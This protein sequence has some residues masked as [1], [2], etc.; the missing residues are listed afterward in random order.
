MGVYTKRTTTTNHLRDIRTARF[1]LK[2][3]SETK[4]HSLC[5]S[6]QHNLP[7]SLRSSHAFT[8]SPD[9]LSPLSSVSSCTLFFR[10]LLLFFSFIFSFSKKKNKKTTTR[11]I[12]TFALSFL[13]FSLDGIPLSRSNSRPTCCFRRKISFEARYL[14]GPGGGAGGWCA[15]PSPHASRI[16]GEGARSTELPVVI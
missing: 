4:A 10:R 13:F 8:L 1:A 7:P 12:I 16:S 5:Y 9:F 3:S 14:S 15:P 2:H 6:V 11:R